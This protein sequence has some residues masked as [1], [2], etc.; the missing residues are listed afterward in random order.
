[1]N[2]WDSLF[3][4]RSSKFRAH[5]LIQYPLLHGHISCD[6][7]HY[8]FPFFRLNQK[9]LFAKR[10]TDASDEKEAPHQ[11]PSSNREKESTLDFVKSYMSK[12]PFLK[13]NERGVS[14]DDHRGKKQKHNAEG[15]TIRDDSKVWREDPRMTRSDDNESWQKDLMRRT[16]NEEVW[17]NYEGKSRREDIWTGK[18]DGK[19]SKSDKSWRNDSKSLEGARSDSSHRKTQ[20]DLAVLSR[21]IKVTSVSSLD[22]PPSHSAGKVSP[23]HTHLVENGDAKI[24]PKQSSR[25]P[26]HGT[27]KTKGD[28]KPSERDRQIKDRYKGSRANHNRR[29]MADKKRKGGMI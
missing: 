21:E 19:D 17:R 8:F 10:F 9:G 18:S 24:P 11:T 1:M 28:P 7:L 23:D 12:D 5:F 26:S 20:H 15:R 22:L 27:T 16:R 4:I 3:N 2:P 13:K 6:I 29:A 25:G 14:E